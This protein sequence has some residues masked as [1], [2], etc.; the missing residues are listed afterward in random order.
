VG[1]LVCRNPFPSRPLGFFNDPDGT[2]FHEAYFS[3]NP[4]MWTHG[5]R[6]AF[7]ARG[8]ARMHGRSDGVLNIRGIRV[9]TSEIYTAL[10]DVAE[11]LDVMAVEQELPD[12]AAGSRIVLLVVLQ[13]GVALTA[14]L[15]LRLRRQ[16]VRHTAAVYVPGAIADVAEL[17]TTHSG[18]RSEVA[19]RDAIN[20]CPVRNRDAL[21]NP[22]CLDVIAAHPALRTG[23]TPMLATDT[24]QS[25]E[26]LLKAIWASAFGV[27]SIGANDDFFALGGDSLLAVLICARI[28][29]VLGYN[30]PIAALFQATAVS[31]L[32]RVLDSGIVW[33]GDSP[34]VPLKEGIGRPVFLLHSV[35]GNV[36]E[37]HDLLARLVCDRPI[38]AVQAR[39]LDPD[40]PPS[41]SVEEMA[42]DYIGLIRAH[43]PEEAMG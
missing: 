14:D 11:L 28:E 33:Q 5:D 42:A 12:N 27:D 18:K 17:P 22:E 36:F 35:A 24:T 4:G 31:A 41:A 23:A 10:Q 8:T 20:A 2:R 37:W 13:P 3:Q 39:G 16:I 38:V 25:T 19:A 7:T 29:E 9:G 6:V 15:A 30:L 43:Q 1:E 40:T 21:R 26:D 32:A 34:L